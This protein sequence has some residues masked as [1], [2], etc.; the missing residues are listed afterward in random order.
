MNPEPTVAVGDGYIPQS[1]T[2][3]TTEHPIPN[4]TEVKIAEA[5]K[6]FAEWDEYA[7]EA[8]TPVATGSSTE[9]FYKE[10]DKVEAPVDN[11]PV[12]S[13]TNSPSIIEEELEKVTPSSKSRIDIIGQNGNT[14]EHY[15]EVEQSES[16]KLQDELEPIGKPVRL[17]P[18]DDIAE[19]DTPPTEEDELVEVTIP[20]ESELRGMTKSKIQREAQALGFTT[21]STKDSKTKMIEN[22]VSSTES[23][24]NDLQDSGEFVSATDSGDT[25]E[26]G[27]DDRDGGY[28]K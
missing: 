1:E 21:V 11:K 23:F 10:V 3:I 13:D 27:S 4:A 5:K 25:D 22:F 26:G 2:T 16:E 20:N 6:S 8:S 12:I 18:E 17:V 28:F 9:E 19:F 24:I 15:E 14:G 7:N